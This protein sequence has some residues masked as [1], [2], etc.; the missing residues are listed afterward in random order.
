VL[1]AV[2]VAGLWMASGRRMVAHEVHDDA[3]AEQRIERVLEPSGD[4]R[5]LHQ[6]PDQQAMVLTDRPVVGAAGPEQAAQ[7]PVRYVE[8]V[9]PVAPQALETVALDG[10]AQPAAAEDANV[11]AGD[12]VIGV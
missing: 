3:L 1:A 12:L 2:V 5:L 9:G 6:V 8:R 11:P 7:P 10:S 4:A